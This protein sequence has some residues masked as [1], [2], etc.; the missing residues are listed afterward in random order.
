MLCQILCCY[1][2]GFII[3]DIVNMN[4]AQTFSEFKLN[5]IIARSY[6]YG[7]VF[8]MRNRGNYL[9]FHLAF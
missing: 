6:I 4:L 3:Y 1:F 5:L 9:Q 7:T 8:S 2:L